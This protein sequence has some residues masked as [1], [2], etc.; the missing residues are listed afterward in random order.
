MKRKITIDPTIRRTL[1]VKQKFW[2]V[3]GKIEPAMALF[4]YIFRTK[5]TKKHAILVFGKFP[6]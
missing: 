3:I 4:F 2:A 1:T 5:V 6:G